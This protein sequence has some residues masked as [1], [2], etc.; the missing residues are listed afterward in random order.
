MLG[1]GVYLCACFFVFIINTNIQAHL[2]SQMCCTY[3]THA[4]GCMHSRTHARTHAHNDLFPYRSLMYKQYFLLNV[5][6]KKVDT[7]FNSY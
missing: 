1:K 7:A 5:S 2:L 4:H 3:L 6:N